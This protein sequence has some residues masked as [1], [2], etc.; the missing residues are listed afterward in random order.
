M[1]PVRGRRLSLLVLAATILSAQIV[2]RYTVTGTVVN[3]AT[4]EPIRRALVAVGGS[5]VFTGADGRFQAD[6]M[7]EGPVMIAAQKPGFFDSSSAK[8]TVTVGSGMREVVLKLVPE[9]R[10]QGRIV[11]EDGEPLPGVE[12]QVS[13][14][15]V[16]DGR[17]QARG[18]GA[19]TT[20]AS[21]HYTIEGLAPGEFLIRT[22]PMPDDWISTG[23][24]GGPPMEV[25]P[26]RYYPNAADLAAAVPAEVRAG[27]S[28]EADFKLRPAPAFQIT[29]SVAGAPA[30][31]EITCED[32][33]GRR[34][35][36]HADYDPK[37]GKFVVSYMPAGTWTLVFETADEEHRLS[38]AKETV[39]VTSKD[40][41]GLRVLLQP[42][43]T[44]P[45]KATNA[46]GESVNLASFELKP[47]TGASQEG[48]RML[49]APGGVAA[50]LNV[51]P[52]TYR[53][54]AFETGD[55]CVDTVTSGNLD[56][57][58][59]LLTIAPGSQPQPIRISLANNCATLDVA[60]RSTSA[61]EKA[62]ILLLAANL[63]GNGLIGF[64]AGS[65]PARFNGVPPGDYSVYAFSDIEGLEYGN[66]EVMRGFQGR[67][68]TLSANQHAAVTVDIN[69]RE[70]Q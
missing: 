57:A 62:T 27:D 11:D 34:F 47:V 56:L 18:E 37:T 51:P 38:Y 49:F 17:K 1:L 16:V 44:I 66:P 32:P 33:M 54:Y 28:V 40:V 19:A 39:T 10:I 68:L 3:S 55:Q 13:A 41:Q 8:A 7:P 63:S 48:Y 22:S 46:A 52:G 70:D 36:L 29:G 67:Q 12:V 23:A 50:I 5:M 24:G 45:V 65:T 26:G 20:N 9:A 53:A 59:E 15:R 61:S 35:G 30:G 25:Y 64:A 58:R 60:I 6:N 4:N 14:E 31:M 69:E 42:L 21:G 2:A 43:A